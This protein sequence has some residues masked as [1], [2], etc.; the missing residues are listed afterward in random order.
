MNVIRKVQKIEPIVR[1]V[2]GAAGLVTVC[3]VG[4]YVY[5]AWR[6]IQ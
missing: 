2:G 6:T 5:Q 1:I 3:A 4:I